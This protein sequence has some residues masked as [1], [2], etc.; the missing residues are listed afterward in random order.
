L[1]D[2]AVTVDGKGDDDSQLTTLRHRFPAHP[3]RELWLR[4]NPDK[5]RMFHQ[6]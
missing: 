3:N 5:V 6:S 4:F 2:A 1:G